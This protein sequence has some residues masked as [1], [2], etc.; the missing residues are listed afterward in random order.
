MLDIYWQLLG[1]A[2]LVFLAGFLIRRS[3]LGLALRVIGD[4]ETVARHIGINTTIAK[5]ALFALSA[6]LS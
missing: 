4:D 2:V 1:L 5:V 3:R 6:C